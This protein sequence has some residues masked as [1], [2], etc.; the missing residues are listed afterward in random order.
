MS[1]SKSRLV[2]V[3]YA[4]QKAWGI[5]LKVLAQLREARVK[6]TASRIAASALGLGKDLVSRLGAP[7]HAIVV[8]N[9]T[10]YR[11]DEVRTRRENRQL[12]SWCAAR[13]GEYLRQLCELHG[14]LV[15]EVP[16]AYTSRQDSVT[17]APGVRAED[18]PV[19]EFLRGGGF[20]ERELRSA[21]RAE[22]M[23]RARS[24]LLL[25]VHAELTKL[26]E[27]VRRQLNCV[28]LPIDG[29]PVFVSADR[30]SLSAKGVQADLNAAANIGIRDR[31]STRLNS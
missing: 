19:K 28:R 15:R 8:E 12:M 24:Q 17:G 21:Q 30:C 25:H 9:L 23:G 26:G 18:V 1:S 4:D 3:T 14:M 6:Q 5:T 13:V 31:K 7:C 11:P 22:K 16:A 10:H 29:G 2:S 20:W 27:E